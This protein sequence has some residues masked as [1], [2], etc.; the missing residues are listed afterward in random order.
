MLNDNLDTQV[1]VK[2]VSR[3]KCPRKCEHFSFSTCQVGAFVDLSEGVG[4]LEAELLVKVVA[5]SLLPGEKTSFEK[6]RL[7]CQYEMKKTQIVVV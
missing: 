3:R 6:T 4:L 1:K 5:S 2:R 7:F